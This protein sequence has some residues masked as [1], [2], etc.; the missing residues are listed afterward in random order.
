MQRLRSAPG[1]QSLRGDRSRSGAAK[2][3]CAGLDSPPSPR[4]PESRKG[5]R[6][7]V[8]REGAALPRRACRPGQSPQ[9]PHNWG[10]REETKRRAPVNQEPAGSKRMRSGSP[11]DRLFELKTWFE[12]HL[13]AHMIGSNSC[14]PGLTSGEPSGPRSSARRTPDGSPPTFRGLRFAADR[15]F[16]RFSY[17]QSPTSLGKTAAGARGRASGGFGGDDPP[18]RR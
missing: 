12:S 15:F 2:G 9:P 17:G 6:R 10:H 3:A 5:L 8:G 14:T 7:D 1:V 18:D 16:A 13:L 4:E 11:G